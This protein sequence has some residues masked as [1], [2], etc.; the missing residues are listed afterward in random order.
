MVLIL[1]KMLWITGQGHKSKVL[2]KNIKQSISEL[3]LLIFH[4]KQIRR[5]NVSVELLLYNRKY[6]HAGNFRD[7]REF[8]RIRENFLHAN[9]IEEVLSYH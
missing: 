4:N 9:I 6:S 2:V 1:A 8:P 7:F 3:L 5:T